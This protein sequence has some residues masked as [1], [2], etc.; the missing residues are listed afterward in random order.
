MSSLFS[1]VSLPLRALDTDL[2][3]RPKDSIESLPHSQT[4]YYDDQNNNSTRCRELHWSKRGK[5]KMGTE[6][7]YRFAGAQTVFYVTLEYHTIRLGE[8]ESFVD[9]L[10][11]IAFGREPGEYC[12]IHGTPFVVDDLERALRVLG[13]GHATSREYAVRCYT[14]RR[15]TKP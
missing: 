9:G 6:L 4:A 1:D 5:N 15:I 3:R 14:N 2:R 12:W 7:Y 10:K 13:H 11:C 8:P